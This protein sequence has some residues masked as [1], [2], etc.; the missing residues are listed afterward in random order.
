MQPT[1]WCMLC[2]GSPGNELYHLGGAIAMSTHW[3]LN[4]MVAISQTTF[5]N[6]FSW[7]KIIVF[8]LNFHWNSFPE[9]QL[10]INQHWYWP[11]AEYVASYITGT[12]VDLDFEGHMAPEVPKHL[13]G[14]WYTACTRNTHIDFTWWEFCFVLFLFLLGCVCAN[15]LVCRG[16]E[17]LYN[18]VMMSAEASQI[19]GPS[20]A[21][22]I[23]CSGA[24]QRK[25]QSSPP[26][27][28]VGGIH[29]WPVDIPLKGP[30]T[31][32]MFPFD[33]VIMI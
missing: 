26:L 29:L 19:I 25:H 8:W 30:I 33:D 20:I 23:V 27:T 7:Q 5:S 32:K 22:S 16:V 3:G 18:D 10:T 28:F 24:D 11:G 14:D 4:K 12:N 6:A 9:V 15:H 17:P 31:W 13:N 21:C 1:T 2:A